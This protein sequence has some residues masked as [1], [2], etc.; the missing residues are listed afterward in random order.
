VKKIYMALISLMFSCFASCLYAD[1]A[2]IKINQ[3]MRIVTQS[4][5]QNL[6]ALKTTLKSSYPQIKGKKLTHNA[7]QFNKL[8]QGIVTNEIDQ[9]KKYVSGDFA[10]MQTLPDERQENNLSIDYDIDVIHPNNHTTVMV[11]FNIE[12]MQ[13]GRAHPYHTHRV[14]NYNLDTGKT[15]ALSELFK[16]HSNY[17]KLI[18]QLS[19]KQLQGK[20]SDKWMIDEGTKADPKNYQN[21]NIQ[22]DTLLITFDEYQVAPYVNGPQE[23]EIPYSELKKVLKSDAVISPCVSNPDSCAKG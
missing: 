12:G 3:N 17:L 4:Q 15:L 7:E 21:W 23:V 19:R 2:P 11:R 13:A 18:A 6:S 5:E 1:E 20:L 14:L 8:V 10:H 9:F 22:N 16:P